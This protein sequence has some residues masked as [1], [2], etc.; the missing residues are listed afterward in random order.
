MLVNSILERS[1]REAPDRPALVCGERRVSYGWLNKHADQLARALMARG[2]ARGGRVAIQLENSIETV[3]AVFA[4]LK[5]GGVFVL[6]NP[7]VK[8]DKLAYIVND[9]EASVLFVDAGAPSM[10]GDTLVRM[11][12]LTTLVLTGEGA[13]RVPFTR[14]TIERFDVLLEASSPAGEEVRTIDLDLAALIYTSGSTGNPKG[15][16]LSHA[17]IV[18]AATSINAYLGNTADD[19]ILNVLPLSFDYGLYQIFLAFMVGASVVLETSFVYPAMLLSRISSERVTALPIVPMMAALFAKQSF[20][21]HDL[22]RLRYITNTG[23]ALPPAHIKSLRA[24]LPHVRIFSMYGLTECKRVS[25]LSPDEIDT[26]PDSVGKAMP[27]VEVYL[28]DE[29]GRRIESG[30][31]ELMIRGAN[32]MQGYW[33]APEQTAEVLLEGEVPGER[34]LRSRDIFCMDDQGYLYF[35]GRTDDVIKCRGQK[36]SPREVENVLHA[37]PGVQ[38]AKVVG[39]ADAV[40]GEAVEAY[41]ILDGTR[42]TS[43]EILRYCSQHIEDFMVPRVVHIVADLP[44]TT[45]GKAA[46]PTAVEQL[47]C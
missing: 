31:G 33:N 19:V 13:P 28:R 1:A 8:S 2:L 20:E 16:M 47:P 45:S 12:S 35:I 29:Q 40:L 6:V 30:I 27:N 37:A 7:T 32:V 11:P 42:T 3:V 38:E 23:A 15:V 21:G 22:S 26:R 44:R 17:N 25:F 39:V 24:R 34:V 14:L 9:C 41:V 10:A 5:A 43:Q 46:R 4:T 18:A 36:V